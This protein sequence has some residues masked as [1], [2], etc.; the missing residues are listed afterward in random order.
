MQITNRTADVFPY[1]DNYQ[2]VT[3]V[4]IVSGATA[5][6]DVTSGQTIILIINEAL[7]YGKKLNHSLLNPNQI[8][9]NGFD[10]QDNPYDKEYELGITISNNMFV[11]FV[12]SGTKIQFRSRVPTHRELQECHHVELTSSS[13]WQPH[14]V[15]LGQLNS[16]SAPIATYQSKTGYNDDL[17]AVTTQDVPLC[18]IISKFTRTI[19][20]YGYDE[21]NNDEAIL[22]SMNPMHIDLRERIIANINVTYDDADV[23]KRRTLISSE[24]HLGISP[25]NI[26]ELWGIG[27]NRAKITIE[28]TTQRGTR[29]ALLPL[30]RRYRADRIYKMK[31]LDGKFA[32]DT[33]T[34]CRCKII[35]TKHMRTNIFPQDWVQRM[36]SNAGCK[37]NNYW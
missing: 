16:L 9:H 1:N 13:L 26:A 17:Y 2:P 28:A 35:I 36:L 4:P 3:N 7:Y 23:P 29:S 33:R 15:Q 10:V 5:Y 18:Y 31:R 6:D 14:T 37:G 20:Q 19:K 30:S 22:H 34:I 27:Y 24:R 12:T 32:T 25:E 21:I 11:K 8:R